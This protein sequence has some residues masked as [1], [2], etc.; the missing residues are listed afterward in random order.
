MSETILAQVLLKLDGVET[1]GDD[2]ARAKRKELVKE[3][4]SVLNELDAMMKK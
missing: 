1:E 3:T 2:T 4:Q